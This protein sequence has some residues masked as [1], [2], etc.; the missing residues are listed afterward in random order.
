VKSSKISISRFDRLKMTITDRKYENKV[1]EIGLAGRTLLTELLPMSLRMQGYEI[2]DVKVVF[3]S[4]PQ[5]TRDN[6]LRAFIRILRAC[7]TGDRK[8]PGFA[9]DLQLLEAA[10]N[11]PARLR[12]QAYSRE[13]PFFVAELGPLWRPAVHSLRRYTGLLASDPRLAEYAPVGV[14]ENCGGIYLKA[15]RNQTC[16]SPK[17]RMAR[18][19][20]AAGREYF[21]RMQRKRRQEKKMQVVCWKPSGLHKAGQKSV[22]KKLGKLVNIGRE[23]QRKGKK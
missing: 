12:S 9:V 10:I 4:K 15:K 14:C 1:R 13:G 17:C 23:K 2:G 11:K 8:A 6:E 7:I 22:V 21:A 16:C 18:W 3:H 5:F 19:G 20:R